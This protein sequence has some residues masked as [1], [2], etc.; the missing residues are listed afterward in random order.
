MTPGPGEKGLDD[1]LIAQ[2]NPKTSLVEVEG[3]ELGK[4][5][6]DMRCMFTFV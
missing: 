3:E 6:A 2:N 4:Q 5:L 1:L